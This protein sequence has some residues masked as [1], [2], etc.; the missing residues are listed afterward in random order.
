MRVY[1]TKKRQKKYPRFY[2]RVLWASVKDYLSKTF[3]SHLAPI[4]LN[5]SLSKLAKLKSLGIGQCFLIST[6]IQSAIDISASSLNSS[7]AFLFSCSS[8]FATSFFNCSTSA[9]L[10]SRT[11]VFSASAVLFSA[12][13]AFSAFQSRFN[14]FVVSTSEKSK[15]L[16]D[17]FSN[18]VLRLALSLESIISTVEKSVLTSSTA[19]PL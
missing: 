8:F 15:V 11:A 16:I 17:V 10:A 9:V 19:L 3:K 5:K 2:S 14:S 7:I 12:V 6:S 4:T 18:S 13:L 1:Y